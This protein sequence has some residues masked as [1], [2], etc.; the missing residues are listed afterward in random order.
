VTTAIAGVKD[1]ALGPAAEPT[2]HPMLQMME[3][4]ASNKDVDVEKLQ[5]LIN[6]QKD[7]MAENAKAAFNASFALMQREL[8]T[9]VERGKT[10]LGPYARLEDIIEAVRPVLGAHGF[11]ISHRTEWPDAKTVK[12]VGILTHEQGHSRE[13]EFLS[14]AD[15]FGSKNAIQG[16]ASAV[17]YGRRYT[18]KD[19]LNIVTREEDDDGQG[20]VPIVEAPEGYDGWLLDM[21]ATVDNGFKALQSAWKASKNDYRKHLADTNQA[22]W[23][24]MKA[25][26]A[27]VAV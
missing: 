13:S 25:A 18:V 24:S 23:E 7:I 27:K 19:L 15:T 22:K 17:S 26:A 9:V 2:I 1:A 20:T 11:S 16:L 8:P 3:R 21:E 6:M 10:N 5:R 4:L 12:V 14:S